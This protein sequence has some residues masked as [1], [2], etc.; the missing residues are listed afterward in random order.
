MLNICLFEC[1]LVL[2][3]FGA[4]LHTLSRSRYNAVILTG[5]LLVLRFKYVKYPVAISSAVRQF[6]RIRNR[7]SRTS[8]IGSHYVGCKTTR[9]AG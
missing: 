6:G 5:L 9:A 7:I 3:K 2:T 4:N 8:L 1:Q